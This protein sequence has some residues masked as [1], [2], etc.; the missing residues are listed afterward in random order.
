MDCQ[1][2]VL[3]GFGAARK[4]RAGGGGDSNRTVPVVALTAGAR[5]VDKETALL[6]GMDDFLLKP[7][8]L[9]ALRLVVEKWMREGKTRRG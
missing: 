5:E 4:I 8:S 7:F 2:P 1:M 3:D 6:S 9:S